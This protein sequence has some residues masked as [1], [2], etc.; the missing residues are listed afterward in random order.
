MIYQMNFIKNK[1]KATLYKV[2][3]GWLEKS[4]SF[5]LFSFLL[6]KLCK[7]SKQS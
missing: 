7:I 1:L 2:F 6:H 3:K 4:F 5:I